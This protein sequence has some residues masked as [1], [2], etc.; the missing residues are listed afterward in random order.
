MAASIVMA[1]RTSNLT[2]MWSGVKRGNI[3]LLSD[4]L[5]LKVIITVFVV[6]YSYTKE[7]DNY[8]F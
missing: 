4:M 1:L 8:V 2:C 3:Y 6:T 7:I 5:I